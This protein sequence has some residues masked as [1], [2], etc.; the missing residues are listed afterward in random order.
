[1]SFETF[2]ICKSDHPAG[3]NLR[4]E[5]A[6]IASSEQVRSI[7]IK[8]KCNLSGLSFFALYKTKQSSACATD[9][10]HAHHKKIAAAITLTIITHSFIVQH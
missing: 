1:M 2:T 8:P 6:S 5:I 4:R 10:R 9:E 3:C 7:F